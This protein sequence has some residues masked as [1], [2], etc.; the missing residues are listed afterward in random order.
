MGKKGKRLPE[1]LTAIEIEDLRSTFRSK[2]RYKTVNRN[3]LMIEFCLQTGTRIS[4][5]INTKIENIDFNI[6]QILLDKTKGGDDRIVFIYR[7]L[8]QELIKYRES[9]N[10]GLLFITLTGK[11]VNRGYLDEMLKRKG[12]RAGIKKRKLHFHVLRHTFAKKFYEKSGYD[13]L[14]LSKV[15]GHRSL[16]TTSIYLQGLNIDE[17]KKVQTIKLFD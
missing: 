8:L 5:L 11:A 2:K 12:A 3:Y 17:I 15:L 16:N 10:S 7:E 6:G 9:R 4:E 1:V 14:S 13:I